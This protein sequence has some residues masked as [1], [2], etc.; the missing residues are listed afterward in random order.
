MWSH[1]FSNLAVMLWLVLAISANAAEN[2][3]D[4]GSVAS[5]SAGP[6]Q[7]DAKKIVGSDSCMKCHGQELAVWKATP[8]F[9]T[10]RDLHKQAEAQAIAD[11]MGIRS[12]K[13]GD[14]C[15]Q[16][17]YT[18]KDLGGRTKAISGV[19]CESC[20]GAAADWLAI[21]SD[22]GGPSVTKADE[23]MEHRL[24]RLEQSIKHGMR[25]PANLYLIARSCFNCHTVPHEQLVNVGGHVAGSHTF[26]LV[27]WSQGMVRH[28]F[29][30]G[31]GTNTPS[32]LGRIR[33]MYLVGQITDLEFSLRATAQATEVKTFG[34]TSARRVFDLRRK[35]A[36]MQNE[37]QNEHLASALEAAY[38]VKLKSNNAAALQ[39]AA[40]RVSEAA[41]QLAEA[42]DGSGLAAMDAYLPAESA[43][44]K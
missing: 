41:F 29:L 14:L 1:R 19:S 31:D 43:Y 39:D 2:S 5:A 12:I 6:L 15:I 26:E 10:F 18:Q 40:E 35:L 36:E 33:L 3:A 28:N 32:N 27:S 22:Y 44:K 34:T 30:R 42:N 38:G 23:T 16:C 21:H 9:T 4:G 7:L 37:L 11:R 24:Q 17:H 20:H 13:R 25:N 8:H